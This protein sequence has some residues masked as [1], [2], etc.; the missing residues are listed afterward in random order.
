MEYRRV[1]VT[2]MGCVTPLGVGLS[3]TWHRLLAGESGAVKL[4][5]EEYGHLPTRIAC[6]VP[7]GDGPSEYNA[8]RVLGHQNA[9]RFSNFA[10]FALAAAK[11]AV[12]DAQW[13]PT[14]LEDLVRTGVL[15]GSGIGGFNTIC[16]TTRVVEKRGARKVNPYFVPSILANIPAGLVAQ[17]YGFQGPNSCVAT[18]CASGAHAI[19]D[20]MW[21]IARGDADV[22]VT[23]S[24]EGAVSPMTIAGFGAA[25]AL[26]RAFND[27]PQRA[28]RPWDKSRDGFVVAEGAGILVLEEVEHA[29]A[30]GA[31]IYGEIVGYGMSG[32]AHHLTAPSPDGQGAK[33]AMRAA[34]ARAGVE[35]NQV[36]YVNAHGTSTPL[37]DG[38]EAA[39]LVE[40]FAENL[41]TLKVSSTK[42]A[43]GHLLGGAGSVE[44][45]FSLLSIRDKRVP[46]TLN[47]EAPSEEWGLN[48]VPH[49][50]QGCEATVVMSNSFG[51]G[52]T[53]ASLLFKAVGG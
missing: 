27:E 16:D 10:G 31:K 11:E 25:R 48:L 23:G 52:G 3:S 14:S 41:N 9:R 15:I 51:F 2:G 47:L 37:G 1:V 45:I 4:P 7:K 5:E 18:A 39:A 29:L 36:D 19:G 30:R 22:M 13:E 26:S 21:I 6:L 20:A 12:E 17:A 49:E 46:P 32:D 34:L 35:P 33:R 40:I 38:V 28:S 24:T 44:A 50:A 8:L 42:S 43:I 53:N